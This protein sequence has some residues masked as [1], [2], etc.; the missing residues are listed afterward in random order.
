M[1]ELSTTL[2]TV[3]AILNGVENRY[4]EGW[5]RF[6]VY[7]GITG[8]GGQANGGELRNPVGSNV[9]AVIEKAAVTMTNSDYPQLAYGLTNVDRANILGTTFARVDPRGRPA[10][11][12]IFS[13][14]NAA[15]SGLVVKSQ[16]AF[17]AAT[18]G[19][20]E[21][22]LFV[23]QEIPL[24]PG[25]AIMISGTALG[26]NIN[27]SYLWRERFLEDSERT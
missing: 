12:L 14:G 26:L 8:V 9:L 24:L 21:F 18:G 3:I 10:P 20:G 6:A 11:T 19:S 27:V 15:G 2:Q 13:N 23:D 17:T 5:D 4:L 16:L 1:N 7:T 25:D 22:I